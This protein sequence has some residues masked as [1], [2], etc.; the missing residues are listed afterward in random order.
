MTAGPRLACQN[1]PALVPRHHYHQPVIQFFGWWK[2]IQHD[3]GQEHILIFCLCVA[4]LGLG[5]TPSFKEDLEAITCHFWT[6]LTRG[7]L[8]CIF[9]NTVHFFGLPCAERLRLKKLS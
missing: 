6:C 2:M 9:L 4:H 1:S 7:T 5:L 8:E 3:G